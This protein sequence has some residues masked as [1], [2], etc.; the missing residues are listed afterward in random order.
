MPGVRDYQKL[1]TLCAAVPVIFPAHIAR[2]EAVVS[3][4]DKQNRDIAFLHRL[5]RL[6]AK[7]G[8]IVDDHRIKRRVH[9]AHFFLMVHGHAAAGKRAGDKELR[10]GDGALQAIG[11]GIDRVLRRAFAAG[12]QPLLRQPFAHIVPHIHFQHPA[13]GGQLAAGD[14]PLRPGLRR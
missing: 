13:L 2:H 4:V 1:F 8:G 10:G 7:R 14:I 3:A 9:G 12:H 6:F 11:I 5:H